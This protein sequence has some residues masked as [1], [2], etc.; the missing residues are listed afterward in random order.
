MCNFHNF[1]K[2]TKP[3][4]NRP[5][6]Y[7]T[8][9]VA[10]LLMVFISR[11]VYFVDD[12]FI[13]FRFAYRLAN[14]DFF[15]W[16]L[17]GPN[18]EGFSNPLWT[19]VS[20]IFLFL[21]LEINTSIF[22]FSALIISTTIILIWY[23]Q[24][25]ILSSKYKNEICLVSFFL[26]FSMPSFIISNVYGL[27]T[28]L[29]ALLLL[30]C[31]IIFTSTSKTNRNSY[32]YRMFFLTLLILT[33]FEAIGIIGLMS[34][35]AYL[36]KPIEYTRKN[37][38]KDMLGILII[39]SIITVIRFII[40]GELLPNTVMAKGGFLKSLIMLKISYLELKNKYGLSLMYIYGFFHD[41]KVASFLLFVNLIAVIADRIHRR[42]F[43][44]F[45]FF[46]FSG[47]L[48]VFMN[49][50]DWM[51]GYR[52]ITPFCTVL[53]IGFGILFDRFLMVIVR[54]AHL[55]LVFA[56]TI[57]FLS[58]I[59]I[60]PIKKINQLE[61][62][63]NKGNITTLDSIGILLN[64]NLDRKVTYVTSMAGRIPFYAPI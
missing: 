63:F 24:N 19:F 9:I 58:F 37:F 38:L 7:I 57:V 26:L 21:D 52:L 2:D 1:T 14:G 60:T 31:V 22:W 10:Y 64:K 27:E 54:P 11:Q 30:K 36:I 49:G 41:N 61:L 25:I 32:F 44:Y 45:L 4:N 6:L 53:V 17:G 5:L 55:V 15:H 23:Y 47:L 8:I 34:V 43:I 56:T 20:A 42:L 40:F 12:A 48:V 33:R 13:T 18:I 51:P 50:G 46:F 28:P 35:G 3:I 16:N 29:F 39:F 59:I 62:Y